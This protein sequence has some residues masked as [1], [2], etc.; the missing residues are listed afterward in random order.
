MIIGI[1]V[2]LVEVSR[3]EK[4]LQQE[5]FKEKNLYGRGNCVL[6]KQEMPCGRIFFRTLCREG[7]GGQG[8]WNRHPARSV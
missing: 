4:A 8:P 1:G 7:S 3:I 2:D 5:G 6:R